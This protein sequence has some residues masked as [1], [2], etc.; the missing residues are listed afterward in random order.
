MSEAIKTIVFGKTGGGKTE[1]VK[2]LVADHSRVLFF[3]TLCHDY[4]QDVIINT[5]DQLKKFWRKCFTGNF[6]IV[7]RTIDHDEDFPKVCRLVKACKNMSFVVEESDLFFKSGTCCRELRKLIFQGRH[8]GVNLYAVT[9][10]P[11]GIGRGL[12]SQT[13][14]FYIF[15]SNEPVDIKYFK[16][17]CGQE[18]A[19]KIKTLGQYEYIEF[20]DYGNNEWS[21]KKDTL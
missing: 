15:R 3:D 20:L 14:E 1:K 5:F 21:I 9:Q 11:F 2:K 16:Y 17:R 13:K 4:N 12:T 10:R 7:Y 19:E 8:Y 18:V 6:R